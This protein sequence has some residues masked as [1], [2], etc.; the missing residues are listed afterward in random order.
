MPWSSNAQSVSHKNILI[1]YLSRTGN[2]KAIAEIIQ[3]KVGGQLVALELQKPYPDNYQAT[4]QQVAAEN[5]AGY[6]PLL[7]KLNDQYSFGG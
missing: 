7:K 5:E 3:K 4:V 2:T 1:V 6:L